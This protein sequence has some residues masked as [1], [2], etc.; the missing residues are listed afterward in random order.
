MAD[1]DQAQVEKLER[2]AAAAQAAAAA[3][4]SSS[5]MQKS[6][7]R[8]ELDHQLALR[9]L[10]KEI[11]KATGATKA[12]AELKARQ[13]KAEE[14]LLE[15]TEKK[16]KA[17]EDAAQK[18]ADF[19]KKLASGIGN[20]AKSAL[21]A[22][23]SIYNSN[24][25]FT[26]VL[27]TLQLVGDTVSL[28]IESAG[29]ALSGVGVSVAGFGVNTG[30]ASE[31][32][33]GFVD[34]GAKLAFAEAKIQIERAQK[35]IDLYNELSK[36]GMA[37]GGNI[38]QMRQTALRGGL[39]LDSFQ[40][41]VAASSQ[42]LVLLG[43]DI[44]AGADRALQ[45]GKILR[46]NN[47]KLLAMYGSFDA[48]MTA[49]TDYIALQ[50]AYGI[51]T[52]NL[53]REQTEGAREYLI[54]QKELSALTG[55]NVDQLKKEQDERAN[56]A[57]YQ[58]AMA[59]KSVHE[60]NNINYALELIR[61]RRGEEAYKYA[62]EYVATQGQVT[63]KASLKFQGMVVEGA[64]TIRDLLTTTN[65]SE[66]TYNANA[67]KI[68]QDRTDIELNAAKNFSSITTLQAGALKDNPIATMLND[69]E[70]SLRR[71]TTASKD[72][73]NAE[74]AARKN[75]EKPLTTAGAAFVKSLDDLENYKKKLDATAEADI[76]RVGK[77]VDKLYDL[78]TQ[79]DTLFGTDS[80]LGKALERF[81][82]GLISASTYLLNLGGKPGE[83]GTTGTGSELDKKAVGRPG[84][85]VRKDGTSF[86]PFFQN[87]PPGSAFDKNK[88]PG[89]S[90]DQGFDKNAIKQMGHEKLGTAFDPNIKMGTITSKS[91][92][93]ATVN[94]NL[95]SRFQSL[96]DFLDN[97]GYK[98]DSLGG[99]N[100][101]QITD[102]NGT[103]E[104]AHSF[105]A[106]IDINPAQ[107]PMQAK[108]MTDLPA[109]AVAYAN[110]LGLGWGGNWSRI[111]DPMHFSA[112]PTEGGAGGYYN[113]GTLG[114][115]QTGIVGENGPELIQG[116]GSVTSTA[117]TSRKF[118]DMLDRLTEMVSIMKEHRNISK[119]LLSVTA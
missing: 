88:P 48:L 52:R 26:A 14:D 12:D 49:T 76:G 56:M 107:N 84:S 54:N 6:Q 36:S 104:S 28:V 17:D 82:D 9:N 16:T 24:K 95:V 72:S 89:G 47:P 21:D 20:F 55:K 34:A 116:P 73:V 86:N 118:D 11:Q 46:D 68:I 111:K 75:A 50:A 66:K 22:S 117:S 67:A 96:V 39:A 23:Q 13:I 119:D 65:Q 40:R 91:G 64:E 58:R 5:K 2:L 70:S 33:A 92:K 32:I 4:D 94:A 41:Y 115:G 74:I 87:N 30:R 37:F 61:A 69:Y 7:A 80:A 99:F 31:A 90:K 57:A 43:G 113:G 98:I 53:T 71:Q 42:Q 10:T 62:V 60:Q 97:T 51:D 85:V 109:E 83:S 103:Y 81:T 45:F 105:G 18:T 8:V 35:Y 15:A 112:Q 38:E 1:L 101:K 110:S 29:K 19:A 114:P 108:L 100:H 102:S 44:Q 78:Q 106:A 27:P 59:E 63:S 25:S 3:I 79:L 77:I 93:T